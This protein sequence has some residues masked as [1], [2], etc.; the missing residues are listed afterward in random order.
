ML[1]GCV[2]LPF[3][4][5]KRPEPPAEEPLRIG[6]VALVNEAE[7]FALIEATL[8]QAP[9]AGT[10][11]Q[12]YTGTSVSAELRATGVRRR[13]FL[14][15]DLVSGM[16]VKGDLVMQPVREAEQKPTEA[17]KPGTPESQPPPPAPKPK[18]WWPRWLSFRVGK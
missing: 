10:K 8:A 15:A 7:R 5:R 11:L 14:V 6:R 13:P 4:H 2:H 17:P 12:T 3:W 18:S 1:A 16:P 9:A